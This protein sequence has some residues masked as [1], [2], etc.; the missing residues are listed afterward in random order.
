MRDRNS[1]DVFAKTFSNENPTLSTAQGVAAIVFVTT[2]VLPVVVY[3]QG[4][5]AR[6][7]AN[8]RLTLIT[9]AA[10]GAAVSMSLISSK[11][12]RRL[13]AISGLLMGIGGALAIILTKAQFADL[14]SVPYL[15]K[16]VFIIA[17]FVGAVPGI[18]VYCY[19]RSARR[20]RESASED[21]KT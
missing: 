21:E 1:E 15:R 7:V 8:P 6:L 13:G 12:L 14:L 17:L 3:I 4:G 16:L 9:S 5:M 11:G 18:A 20:C 10:L 19:F 2:V